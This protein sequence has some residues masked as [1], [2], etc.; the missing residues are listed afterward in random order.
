MVVVSQRF[1]TLFEG[2]KL[3]AAHNSAITLPLAYLV[4]RVAYATMI[5]FMQD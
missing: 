3:N 1:K 2:L 4:R 5:V